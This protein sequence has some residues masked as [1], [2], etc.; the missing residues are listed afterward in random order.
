M[1]LEDAG[2]QVRQ[3]TVADLDPLVP[4]FD[5]YRRFYGRP[6]DPALA[7]AFLHERFR[8]QQS[9]VFLALR[10]DGAAVG[11]TQLY[12]S[13]SSVSAARL[14]VLNDL[15]VA[16]EARRA[17]VGARLL[18]AAAGYARAVGAI[19]LTLSTAVDN[20]AAQRLYRAQGWTRDDAFQ[21]YHLAL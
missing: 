10:A 1:S 20:T 15:F 6:G 2:L 3:A 8:H 9:V 5:A 13:F 16:P 11:F 7:R 17:G 14:F 18:Q 4:L 21:V 12:P 19:G